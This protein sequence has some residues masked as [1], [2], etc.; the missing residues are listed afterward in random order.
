MK[1]ILRSASGVGFLLALG[2][3]GLEAQAHVVLGF[4]GGVIVPTKGEKSFG[5]DVKSLGYNIEAILGVAPAKGRIT[6]RVDGMYSAINFK[7]TSSA[8]PK[9]KLFGID[10]DVVLHPGTNGSVRPYLMAGPSYLHDSYRSGSTTGNATSS[11]IGFNGGAGLNF[12]PSDKVWF[13]LEGRFIHTKDHSFF[14]FSLGVRINPRPASA[15]K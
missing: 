8:T 11:N 6:F 13:F 4:G 14:P 3:A 12:G 1:G 2:A 15:K 5:P 10:A 9:D 7:S